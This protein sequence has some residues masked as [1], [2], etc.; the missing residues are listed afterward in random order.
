[1]LKK[2]ANFLENTGLHS[3]AL[4]RRKGVG[5]MIGEGIMGARESLAPT[6]KQKASTPHNA[7]MS[8]YRLAV[9][10]NDTGVLSNRGNRLPNKATLVLPCVA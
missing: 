4:S 7:K 6:V 3:D 9:L 5:L 10:F 1:M 2:T 8:H